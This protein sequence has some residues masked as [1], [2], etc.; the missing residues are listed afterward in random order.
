LIEID[1][2]PLHMERSAYVVPAPGERK[3]D[4]A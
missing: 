2:T 3:C 1:R 4:L